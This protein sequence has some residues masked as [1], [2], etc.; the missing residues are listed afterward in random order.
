MAAVTEIER[1]EW[2]S[3]VAPYAHRVRYMAR[4]GNPYATLEIWAKDAGRW[5]RPLSHTA[6]FC[7]ADTVWIDR[8][9]RRQRSRPCPPMPH[10]VEDRYP[11]H[12]VYLSPLDGM[13]GYT[14]DYLYGRQDRQVR[15]KPGKYLSKYYPEIPAHVASHW[16]HACAPKELTISSDSDVIADVYFNGPPSCQHPASDHANDYTKD[17]DR[18]PC[19]MYAGPDLAI[20]YLGD[21]KSAIARSIVWPE[22]KVYVRVYGEMSLQD[23][24]E[25]LG[26][27]E[28]DLHGAKCRKVT[29]GDRIIVPYVDGASGIADAGDYLIL[30]NH[31]YDYGAKETCGYV[32]EEETY[33][34]SRG[35]CD[36]ERDEDD[37]YCSQCQEYQWSCEDCGAEYFSDETCPNGESGQWCETCYSD[38]VTCCESCSDQFEEDAIPY[39]VRRA[40]S[41]WMLSYCPDCANERHACDTCGDVC[42]NDSPCCSVEDEDE[43]EDED[44]TQDGDG[45]PDGGDR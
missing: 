15:M 29:D 7:P 23:R 41:G 24:L 3:P 20:A 9:R 11:E 5:V 36:R 39:R 6:Y 12:F 37:T 16:V 8:E 35:D 14:P 18:H 2:A 26:Y 44:E 1:G 4:G 25:A 22:K 32:G 21:R 43:D 27:Q 45:T 42:E 10:G 28:G 30:K 40:R 38:H 31:G 13:I 33:Y 34:C 19:R 17:W